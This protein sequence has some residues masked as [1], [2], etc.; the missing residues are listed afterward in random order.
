MSYIVIVNPAI[1]AGSGTG[2]PFAGVLSATVLVAF[3]MTLMMGLY[4]RLPF[5]V[6]PG[7]GLQRV[8]R[9]HHRPAGQGAVA[10]RRSASCSGPASCS[11]LISAT[12]LRERIATAIPANLAAGDRGGHRAAPDVHRSAQRRA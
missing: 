5:A 6:A 1:L 2:M 12:P 7:M 11:S 3:S 8:L 4:A 9:L 10:D